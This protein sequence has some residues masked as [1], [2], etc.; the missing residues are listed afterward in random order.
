MPKTKYS[1]V[2]QDSNGKFFYQIELGVDG[3]I[4]KRIQKKGEEIRMESRLVL[5]VIQIKR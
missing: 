2:Y 5:L 1:C 3:V 4:G